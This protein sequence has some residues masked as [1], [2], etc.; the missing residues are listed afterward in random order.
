MSRR[1]STT[2][3]SETAEGS[4][5]KGLNGY[6]L[7]VRQNREQVKREFPNS[8]FGEISKEVG[9]RWRSLSQSEKNR[10]NEMAL[11]APNT[12]RRTRSAGTQKPRGKSGYTIYKEENAE[13]FKRRF[14]SDRTAIS[15]A[16]KAGY[17]ALSQ[18]EREHF[19]RRARELPP[20]TS[21]RG[22]RRQP[23]Q[24]QTNGYLIFIK[25]ESDRAS[26]AGR[27]ALSPRELG[28]MW[29]ELDQRTRDEYLN[30][31][32]ARSGKVVKEKRAPT[33]FILYSADHREQVKRENP[34][35]TFGEL[36]SILGRMW[37][38][39]RESVKQRYQDEANR[40]KDR[41]RGSSR[42]A[43]PAR[44]S[45]SPARRQSPTRGASPARRQS[46]ARAIPS[47]AESR[48]SS[49][50]RSTRRES[51]RRGGGEGP[52]TAARGGRRVAR[53]SPERR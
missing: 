30:R 26:S 37:R 48:A 44:R 31:G 43:S 6:T 3:R 10:Y 42:A 50:P 1:S 32:K 14:G 8:T 21:R 11:N 27:P 19:E 41:L 9:A 28:R 13:D 38:E 52:T 2:Q 39:E 29:N 7:Y 22:E 25:E 34:G 53:R 40:A 12:P 18:G 35:A 36:G 16:A 17:F 23:K 46:P 47:R 20:T 33:S 51:P 4:K 49:P 45:A 15:A 5:Q 24:K